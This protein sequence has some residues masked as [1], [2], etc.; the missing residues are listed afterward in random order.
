MIMNLSSQGF[1]AIKKIRKVLTRCVE[2]RFASDR[3]IIFMLSGGLDSSIC[4]ALGAE[5]AKK[6]NKKIKTM[7][8]GMEGGTDQLYAELVAKHLDTEHTMILKK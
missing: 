2:D 1:E 6:E 8:I 5:F 4:C 3:E 7:C